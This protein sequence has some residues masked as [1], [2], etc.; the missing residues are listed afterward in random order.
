[1]LG[2]ENVDSTEQTQCCS[3]SLQDRDE[4]IDLLD[5][6]FTN[7]S[8][9]NDEERASVYYICGYVT[10]KERIDSADDD[11]SNRSQDG[12]EFTDLVSR[13]KLKHPTPELYDLA[14]YMY[15][16][17]KNRKQKCCSKVFIQA[18]NEIYEAYGYHIDH[19]DRIIRRFC[20]TFFKGFSKQMSD[21]IRNDKGLLNDKKKRKLASS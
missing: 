16:F 9:L 5:S 21:K 20:N 6:C 1:M 18:F 14:L 19:I 13:G 7:A 3:Q 8:E 12:S 11:E 15:T 17:F 2:L 4:D 10:F